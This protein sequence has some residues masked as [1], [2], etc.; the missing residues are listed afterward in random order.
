MKDVSETIMNI[1]LLEKTM[2]QNVPIMAIQS[3]SES[4]ITN[5]N[6]SI[7]IIRLSN[8]DNLPIQNILASGKN[9]LKRDLK[10]CFL[11]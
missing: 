1:P 6:E 7:P 5:H 2:Q 8:S 3:Y 9:L 10:V 4:Q 11:V